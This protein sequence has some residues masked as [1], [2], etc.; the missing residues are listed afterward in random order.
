MGLDDSVGSWPRRVEGTSILGR[1]GA[2]SGSQ[3][4]EASPLTRGQAV[5]QSLMLGCSLSGTRELAW[6]PLAGHLPTG[7]VPR[8]TLLGCSMERVMGQ[9]QGTR[10]I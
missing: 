7:A 1:A 10:D 6:A 8:K 3:P 4:D 5:G 9:I 2:K